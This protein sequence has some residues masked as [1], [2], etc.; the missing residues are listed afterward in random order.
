MAVD[1]FNNK[2][3]AVN[4]GGA[5]KFD[6]TNW[7]VYNTSNS[8]IPTNHPWK[9]AID[10][11]NNKWFATGDKGV[12]KFDDITWVV[13]DTMNSNIPFQDVRTIEAD[14]EEN[15]WISSLN[16]SIWQGGGVSV[17]KNNTWT[18]YTKQ[19]SPLTEDWVNYI[20]CD[21]SM[22]IWI[23]TNY[24]GITVY[25][26]NGI[27]LSNESYWDFAEV[28]TGYLLLQNYPN[29]FNPVTTIKFNIPEAGNVSLRIYDILGREIKTLVD[30]F[31]NPGNYKVDF[32][33]SSLASGVYIYR[34]QAG[35]Y[36]SSKKMVLIK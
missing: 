12:L 28:P 21:D 4:G 19:N 5:V 14:K 31:K 2:W 29:P 3:F 32:N 23:A 1:K 11:L 17:Y 9:V 15:I 22:N 20:E 16:Y 26:E 8:Q 34:L 33:A 24:G 36:F 10:S 25:N 27:V 30:E 13:F 7:T 35:N 18:N 6:D